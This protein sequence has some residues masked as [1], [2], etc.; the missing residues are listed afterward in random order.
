MAGFWPMRM[1][2]GWCS[3]VNHSTEYLM[4]GRFTTPTTANSDTASAARSGGASACRRATRPKN[5]NSSTSV[6]TVRASH[7]QPV[8]QVGIPQ[9]MPVASAAA[10]R[11]TPTGA[12]AAMNRSA[13]FMRHTRNTTPATAMAKYTLCATCT[14]GTCTYMMRK[15]SPCRR[16]GGTKPRPQTEPTSSRTPPTANRPIIHGREP[17]KNQRGEPVLWNVSRSQPRRFA[18]RRY[19]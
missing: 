3:V 17:R 5:R 10:V 16:S 11:A 1:L 7:T 14:A 8:P 19:S 9:T 15:L 13:I 18:M 12:A 6:E 4:R 2:G